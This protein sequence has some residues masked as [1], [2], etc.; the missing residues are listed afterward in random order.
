MWCFSTRMLLNCFQTAGRS[1]RR[2]GRSLGLAVSPLAEE[3]GTNGR[4]NIRLLPTAAGPVA[5][6]PRVSRSVSQTDEE[7]LGSLASGL[8][9]RL[10]ALEALDCFGRA[11]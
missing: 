6:Q 1:T 7:K 10:A 4:H 3:C 2:C 11:R 8:L 9:R 5:E